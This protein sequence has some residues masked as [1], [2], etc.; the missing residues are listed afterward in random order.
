MNIVNKKES[1]VSFAGDILAL[2][3]SLWLTLIIRHFAIPSWE[4]LSAHI[5]AF[6][7]LFLVWILIF[8]IAGLY[9]RLNT[10]ARHH[11]PKLLFNAQIINVVVAV[12]FFYFV[13]FFLVTPK[14]ILFIYLC[15]SLGLLLLW[16]VFIRPRF[17]FSEPQK[18]LLIAHGE[19]MRE[20][21]EEVNRGK[22]GFYFENY[23]NVEKIGSLD[24]HKEL[25]EF[26]YAEDI[27]TVVIDSDDERIRPFFNH[28]YNLM[29]SKVRFI[30]MHAVYEQVFGKIPVSIIGHSWFLKNITTDSHIMYD[31][32]KRLFDMMV[33]I[34]IGVVSLVFYPFI[35]LAIKLQD[36]GPI[37]FTQERVGQ[38]NKKIRIYKF[39]TMSDP[40]TVTH[41]GNILRKTRLDELPQIWNVIRGDLSLVGPRPEK[42]DM[43]ADYAAHIPY[44]NVRH[45]I[46]PGLSGWAQ[47]YHEHHPHHA[48]DVDETRN[49]LS[50]DLYYVKNRSLFLD[51]EIILKT[52]RTILMQKGK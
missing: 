19:E 38:D 33:A 10:M 4:T 35:C 13:P 6:T 14:V 3:L 48:L 42:V 50:Y 51:F 44:Y 28:F 41:I 31:G 43:V 24:I 29:F 30:D 32:I 17:Y 45:L 23:I 9:D 21:R 18:S 22:Y 15:V 40:V 39:R 46:K 7:S 52:A 12:L 1:V 2:V 5:F 26:I 27:K 49:K 34:V 37:F 16:R 8:Y 25:V 11:L 47:I 20:L 36:G